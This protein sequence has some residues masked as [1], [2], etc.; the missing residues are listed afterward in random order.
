MVRRRLAGLMIALGL[1]GF[2]VFLGCCL[3][4]S[5][6]AVSAFW[7]ASILGG[8]PPPECTFNTCSSVDPVACSTISGTC[9]PGSIVKGTNHGYQTGELNTYME[10][11]TGQPCYNKNQQGQDTQCQNESKGCSSDCTQNLQQ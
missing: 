7:G 10:V 4:L 3:I 2:L 6:E 8:V 11:D 1:P 9:T 5:P